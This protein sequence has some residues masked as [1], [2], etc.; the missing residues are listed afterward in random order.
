MDSKIA[1]KKFCSNVRHFISQVGM[2]RIQSTEKLPGPATGRGG[3][4]ELPP[5]ICGLFL[6]PVPPLQWSRE[7]SL[8][9]IM[10]GRDWGLGNEEWG[11]GG[12]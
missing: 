5:N 6:A 12:W 11:G 7:L 2:S 3:R 10:G 8:H 4:W 9:N 1:F